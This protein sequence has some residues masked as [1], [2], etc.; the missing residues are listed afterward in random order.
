M[1]DIYVFDQNCDDFTNFGLVGALTPIS[2][3]FE[4]EANGLS[5]ITLEHPIDAIGRYTALKCNNIIMADVP[6]R[7]TPEIDGTSIVTSVE[8]WT[9]R[10][11]N[12]ITKAQRTLYKKAS[13]GK[14][15]KV[16]PAGTT[17]TVTKK[18][19]EGRYKVK[20]RYGTG[21]VSPVA[22]E[23]YTNQTIA[24][25]SQS[26][27]TVQPAWTVKPQLFRIYNVEKGIMGLTVMARHITYDLLYNL[28]TYKNTGA[29]SCNVALSAIMDGCIA[30][31]EFDAYTNLAT[32]RTG[33][34]WTR[35]NPID[36][37][38]N[39]ET[40]LAA[41]YGASLVR[42]NWELYVLHDPGINR[43]VTVEY[44]KNMVG[45]KYTESFDSVVTRIIPVGETKDGDD[46]LLSDAV[47]WIDSPN[48]NKYPIVYAQE[49]ICENCKVGTGGVTASI[50]RA[51][52]K[53][54]AQA[55]FD[56]GGDLPAVEMSVDFIN[57]GDTAEYVQYKDL[58]R[59]FLWDYVTIRHKLHGIDV[60]SRIVKIEWDC[61][62]G[63]M[64]NMEIGSVGKTLANSG[65]T[66]WQIPVGFS[67]SKIASG[68][69][70][71]A[72]LQTDIISARH[73]QSD[74]ISTDALQAGAV[75][76]EKIKAG[77]ITA[78]QL[79]ADA[80]SAD[81][82]EAGALEAVTAKIEKL[83]SESIETDRLAA[84]L[85]AFTVVSAGTASF[86]MATVQ[87]LLSEAL[88]LQ[89]GIA[90]SMMITN[91]AITSA[92]ILNATLG[93][94]VIR[95][96]DGLH[97]RIMIGSDGAIRAEAASVTDDEASAGVTA[98]GKQIVET[99][100]NVQDLNAEN[101]RGQSA[102][103]SEIFTDALTAGKI[104]AAEAMLATATIP[105]L[106]ATTITALGNTLDL[107]ANDSI[108]MSVGGKGLGKLMRLDEDGVHVGEYGTTSEVLIDKSAVSVVQNGRK[109]SQ[110]A[111]NYAQFGDYQ[112]RRSA[113]GGIVFKI[114][115]GR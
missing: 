8:Q 37:L 4:E 14:K 3:F 72:A 26:I 102:I 30:E 12:T 17:V 88:I 101:I 66:T 104:T 20:T 55:I 74:S 9:V 70:G 48:I 16:L 56:N 38:L 24:D 53:E 81:M 71:N 18:S 13:G 58:E 60:T 100:I 7:T 57:L 40:G 63:R 1:A 80:I 10:A 36:A 89:D 112:M 111:S 31:H 65:I 59:L 21:W 76:S 32:I 52:M 44:G 19:D 95:G 82:V 87:H 2:C 93:E 114:K 109:Y 23:Y 83:T 5:E 98:G 86:D 64:R 91:L 79:A 34:N 68:T 54:Q 43:G 99:A 75:T 6:V 103:I 61:M 51:R 11:S 22:L 105:S 28:T 108:T 110:F 97:Y 27:E 46:L 33:I 96:E 42:D 78:E 50:A 15:I 115:G 84:A 25:N 49:L 107:S 67:G 77:S 39:P 62:L 29:V 35:K 73:I 113:D 69:I 90:D 94:L 47:K 92:N 85:A 45:I 106:Y 41:L